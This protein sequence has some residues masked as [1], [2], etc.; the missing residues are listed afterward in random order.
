MTKDV[1]SLDERLKLTSAFGSNDA[2]T[3]RGRFS[4]GPNDGPERS[5]RMPAMSSHASSRSA[6]SGFNGT[7]RL[8]SLAMDFEDAVDTV[9]VVASDLEPGQLA[10]AAAGECKNTEDRALPDSGRGLSR[11]GVKKASAVLRR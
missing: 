4:R 2:G 9:T 5:R 10:D 1:I 11:R 6:A 8:P 3:I 7:A